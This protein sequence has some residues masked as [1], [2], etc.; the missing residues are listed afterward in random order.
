MN[1]HATVS[2]SVVVTTSRGHTV[3]L[4]TCALHALSATQASTTDLG[5]ARKASLVR[6]SNPAA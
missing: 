2:G 1:A 4:G 6:V 5:I 3:F